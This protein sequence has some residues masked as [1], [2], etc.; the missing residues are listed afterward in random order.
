M[1]FLVRLRCHWWQTLVE[2]PIYHC[3][4][5]PDMAIRSRQSSL[6]TLIKQQ[7]IWEIFL[8]STL[9]IVWRKERLFEK[10]FSFELINCLLF[11]WYKWLWHVLRLIFFRI[12]FIYPSIMHRLSYPSLFSTYLWRITV[13]YRSF[14]F[15]T[16]K[17]IHILSLSLSLTLT[18][19]Y[20]IH[21][22]ILPIGLTGLFRKP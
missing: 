16:H 5:L 13:C 10:N 22:N 7:I 18:Y 20:H 17:R 1:M 4:L 2:E 9:F 14:P 3:Y 15:L 11:V 19:P 21:I 8:S 12:I 6:S